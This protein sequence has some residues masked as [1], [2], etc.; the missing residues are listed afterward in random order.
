[1]GIPAEEGGKNPQSGQERAGHGPGGQPAGPPF[2]EPTAHGEQD[3]EAGQREGG[4]QPDQVEHRF[5][6]R[7]VRGRRRSPRGGV[8]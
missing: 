3:E 8:A 2:A 7:E 6:L 1:M 5:S 4:Y